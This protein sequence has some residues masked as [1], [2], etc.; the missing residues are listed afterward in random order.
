MATTV[1][2]HHF[3]SPEAT[4][5][6]VNLDRIKR[7]IKKLLKGNPKVIRFDT[8]LG[9]VAGSMLLSHKVG[10]KSGLKVWAR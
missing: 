1:H 8:A 7:V 10:I 5:G 2:S 4:V 9:I 6:G 3:Y